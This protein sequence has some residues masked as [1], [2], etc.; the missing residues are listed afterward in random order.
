MV[1]QQGVDDIQVTSG[2]PL[3]GVKVVI[4]AILQYSSAIDF[5]ALSLLAS[6]LLH[7]HVDV[8]YLTLFQKLV[9][10]ATTTR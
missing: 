1:R 7:A 2:S 4:I 5:G 6:L 10:L 8:L 3:P 9:D